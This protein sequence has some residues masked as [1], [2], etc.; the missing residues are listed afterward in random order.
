MTMIEAGL[1]TPDGTPGKGY[2]VNR[3]ESAK[4]AV[5]K[6]IAQGVE[7][8]P[9]KLAEIM[10]SVG[11][12]SASVTAAAAKLDQYAGIK[13]AGSVADGFIKG[14][15]VFADANGNGVWD[16]GEAK[17]TT[18]KNGN[19]TLTNAKGTLIVTGGTDIS[20]NLPHTGV[21]KAPEGSKVVN[22]LTALQQA[23]VEQGKSAAEAQT[24]VA[25][26]LGLPESVNLQDYDPLATAFSSTATSAERATAVKLQAAAA[27]VQNLL[28][29]ASK[30]L[31]GAAGSGA[32]AVDATKAV[33]ASLASNITKDSDGVVSLSD[34][35]LL[36]AVLT[37][38]TANTGNDAIKAAATKVNDMAGTFATIVADTAEKVDM[39]M[40]ATE[41]THGATS[42]IGLIA[43][44]QTAT[45]GTVADKIATAAATG[46]LTGIVNEVTGTGLLQIVSK[47][48][49]GDLDPR[50]M[51]D[52][53]VIDY[54]NNA[55]R[56]TTGGGDTTTPT[57]TPTFTVTNTAGVVTFSGDATGH[58]T[59]TT[60]GSVATFKK[61]TVTASTMVDLTGLVKFTVT[62]GQTLEG[63]AEQLS[64][65]SI[66]GAGSAYVTG[67]ESFVTADLSTM[68]SAHVYA[69]VTT[70]TGSPVTLGAGAK[71]GKAEVQID[72]DGVFGLSTANVGTAAFKV[73]ADAKLIG[74][75]SSLTGKT[76]TGPGAVEVL[77]LA[78]NTD[79]TGITN[80]GT[81]KATVTSSLSLG[82]VDLSN[83]DHLTVDNGNNSSAIA[84][85]ASQTQ[86]D[87]LGANVTLGVDDTLTAD[88]TAPVFN[89]AGSTPADDGTGVAAGSNVTLK[90]SE[91]LGASKSDLNKVYLKD[92]ATDATVAAAIS[93]SNDTVV[94][95]P[96]ANLAE[97]TAYY[98]TWDAGA[99]KDAAGNAVTAV[100]NETTFNFTTANTLPT[101][102]GATLADDN[103]YID[104]TFSE[105]VYTGSDGTGA[106]TATDLALTFTQNTGTATGATIASV[107][108]ADGSA[109]AGGE[110]TVRVNLTLTGTPSG[111]ETIEVKPASG[112]AIYDVQTG[113]MAGTQSSGTKT[114]AD[115]TVPTFNAAGSTPAD[116][117]TGVAAGSN[118]TLKFSE[119][120]DASKSDLNK[121]YLK[122]VATDATVAAA[123]S[124]S[125][126]TVVINP[127]A[128]LAL[129][130]NYYVT[131]DAGALKDAAGNAVTAVGD[132]TTFNFRT[133]PDQ[134]LNGSNGPDT[135]AGAS[136]NDTITGGPGVDDL[137]GGN[138]SDTF[139]FQ[140]GDTGSNFGDWDVIQDF[141]TGDLIEFGGPAGTG[142]NYWE[143]DGSSAGTYNDLLAA[144]N[145]LF[146]GTIQY[147]LMYDVFG[148][149]YGYL[150]FDRDKVNASGFAADEVIELVGISADTEFAAANII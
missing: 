19:F 55:G 138:G 137:T 101:I 112:A 28:V 123:I 114:L 92:V 26:A 39:V 133:T 57:T 146:D 128:N 135:L 4:Q 12:D 33:L 49:I 42:R 77:A 9:A 25:K 81:L 47:S 40:N 63:T 5:E 61:G 131:W 65:V 115:Q 76:V 89:A 21:L 93:I 90:F 74:P 147:I 23:L 134:T 52:L 82:E 36:K 136:G 70:A 113:A 150:F 142:S 149:G 75:A 44:V 108:K 71:L 45:Q 91:N 7:I 35:S 95:H 111:A 88:N 8:A 14:A 126:D 51:T 107:T 24:A 3:L 43:Q 117:G 69:N 31:V 60:N 54:I 58:I 29:T 41:T 104:L 62:S 72:G 148:S 80:S 84:V 98:V 100:S 97:G 125:N 110:T 79:L 103:S 78:A 145:N 73:G 116:D 17:T 120:L 16:E 83:V 46:A 30:A 129:D 59:F 139:V 141:G 122:D 102:T 53:A 10:S 144:V 27:K 67:L 6:Q 15:T 66:E 124:I 96:T 32:N 118:V 56:D 143:D 64:G 37:D 38:S 121:V 50:E 119:N 94:I 105:G 13:I 86:I 2:I 140:S 22:P 34:Q 87:A 109:L 20:T 85:T 68:S 106:L 18:D 1:G 132:E 11:A 99:L 127:T 130:T 48:Q